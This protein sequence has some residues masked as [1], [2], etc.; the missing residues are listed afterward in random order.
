VACIGAVFGILALI[1][2]P[3]RTHPAYRMGMDLVKNDPAVIELFG[4]PVI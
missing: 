4:S 3:L 1:F 2:L